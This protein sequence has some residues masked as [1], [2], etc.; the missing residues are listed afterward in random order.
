MSKNEI[1]KI[2]FLCISDNELVKQKTLDLTGN[3]EFVLFL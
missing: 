2:A 1:T 3:G